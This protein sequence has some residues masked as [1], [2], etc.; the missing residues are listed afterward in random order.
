M[1]DDALNVIHKALVTPKLLYTIPA[2][3]GFTAASDMQ[4][5]DALIRRGVSGPSC[6]L[7]RWCELL[8]FPLPPS[9]LLFLVPRLPNDI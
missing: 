3:W 7:L 5:L 2:W 6:F 4:K 8:L 9:L 1:C